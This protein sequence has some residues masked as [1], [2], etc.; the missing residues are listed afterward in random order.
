M[1]LRGKIPSK[2][3]VM[4]SLSPGLLVRQTRRYI[5]IYKGTL[6]NPR[7]LFFSEILT[8]FYTNIAYYKPGGG[9]NFVQWNSDRWTSLGNVFNDAAMPQRLA[10]YPN[11][12]PQTVGVPNTVCTSS[13][14][15][16]LSLSLFRS[17]PNHG[18]PRQCIF[19]PRRPPPPPS[20]PLLFK[21]NSSN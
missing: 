8:N 3:I 14:S 5:Y 10:A 1:S 15:L 19:R 21:T 9:D 12:V 17:L 2:E 13:F 18:I 16:S 11:Q 20:P 4:V 6:L 7:N